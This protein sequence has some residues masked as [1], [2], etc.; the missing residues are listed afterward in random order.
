MSFF[1]FF[2]FFLALF[3]FH[4]QIYGGCVLSAQLFAAKAYKRG[5]TS[6][7]KCHRMIAYRY[8]ASDPWGMGS[9]AM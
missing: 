8:L 3:S 2:F 7:G 4:L 1:F 9:A 6:D 5:C